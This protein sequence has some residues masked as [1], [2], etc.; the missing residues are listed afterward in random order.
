MTNEEASEQ[1]DRVLGE[2][3]SHRL[4]NQGSYDAAH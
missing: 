4:H 1:A 2:G 3:K